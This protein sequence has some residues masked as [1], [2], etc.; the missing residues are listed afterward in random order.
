MIYL[1]I[2]KIKNF[3]FE[4]YQKNKKLI[5]NMFNNYFYKKITLFKTVE[6]EN[7]IFTRFRKVQSFAYFAFYCI[8]LFRL[9][10]NA[11]FNK[12]SNIFLP[13]E[14]YHLLILKIL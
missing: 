6:E 4:N 12:F 1:S 13:S 2:P 8:C 3:E 10:L 14:D 5:V 11:Y 9:H 7:Y